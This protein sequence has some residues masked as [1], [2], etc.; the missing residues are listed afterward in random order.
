[1]PNSKKLLKVLKE[2]FEQI[3]DSMIVI[4]TNHRIILFNHASEVLLGYIKSEVIGFDL[5]KLIPEL[6]ERSNLNSSTSLKLN[7][8]N[9]IKHNVKLHT[10]QGVE[11][12]ASVAISQITIDGNIL[13]SVCIR[14]ITSSMNN[15]TKSEV[16]SLVTDKT[17]HGILITD[18]NGEVIYINNG[19]KSLLG[20]SECDLIGLLPIKVIIPSKAALYSKLIV[21]NLL[22]G[23]S[24]RKDELITKKNGDKMWCSVMSNPIFEQEKL[25]YCVTIINDIT[26]TKL[27]EIFHDKII[28]S[29]AKD[30]P[31]DEVMTKVCRQIS[32]LD[33]E[34]TPAILKLDAGTLKLIASPKLPFFYRQILANLPVGENVAS[35]GTAAFRKE[36]V[37]VTDI[38]KDPLWENYREA[39]KPLGYTGCLSVPIKGKSHDVI[40]VIALYYKKNKSPTDL[41]NF[42]LNVISPLCALSIEKENQKDN[43]QQLVHYDALTKLPNRSLFYANAEQLLSKAIQVSKKLAVLFLDIDKFKSIN[44]SHGHIVGDTLLI[45][46]AARIN[47]SDEKD[48]IS[49]RLSGDEFVIART[50][51]DQD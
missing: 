36:Q 39:I 24:L 35:S 31:C 18:E 21:K 7:G 46:L 37:L 9:E 27:H 12:W 20:Y 42:I 34:L 15:C 5:E 23:K 43:I 3:V 2:T 45:E 6:F 26:N 28:T 4:D 25:T 50:F 32:K 11:N 33:D 44:D 38:S 1:M 10:K 48:C 47:K 19:F 51:S 30:E 49:G 40:G 16:I 8:K 41:H 22:S 14:N 17:D 13:Y 29:I